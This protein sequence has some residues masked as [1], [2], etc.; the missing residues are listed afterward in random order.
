MKRFSASPRSAHHQIEALLFAL[1]HAP[2]ERGS[3]VWRKRRKIARSC[4]TLV[5]LAVLLAQVIAG[6]L[7]LWRLLCSGAIIA[8][9]LARSA[10][11]EREE[12]LSDA[13]LN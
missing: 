6:P 9:W 1:N 12:A 3:L 10:R 7:A 5:L 13:T 11:I 2:R 8:L 4:V